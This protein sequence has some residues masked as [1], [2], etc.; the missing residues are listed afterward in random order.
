MPNMQTQSFPYNPVVG[1]LAAAFWG[2]AIIFLLFIGTSVPEFENWLYLLPLVVFS[3]LFLVYFYFK[4]LIPVLNG[5]I[6]LELDEEKVKFLLSKRIIYWK[7]VADV[8][9]ENNTRTIYFIMLDGSK[10]IA[11]SL[12][13]IKGYNIDIFNSVV[14]CFNNSHP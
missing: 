11:I 10:D 14:A 6:A 4:Y 13:W 8:R 2:G 3:G 12:P 5:K 1:W 9:L 7:D